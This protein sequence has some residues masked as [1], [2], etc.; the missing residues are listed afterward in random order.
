MFWKLRTGEKH[1]EVVTAE[2]R[3]TALSI[4]SDIFE[5]T[6]CGQRLPVRRIPRSVQG[7]SQGAA[8]MNERIHLIESCATLKE[9][10]AMLKAMRARVGF[11][12]GHAGG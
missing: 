12:R 1:I 3:G 7:T 8:T 5:E 2:D 6:I 9:A 11:E 10:T 4:A